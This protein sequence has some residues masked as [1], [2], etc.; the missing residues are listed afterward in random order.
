[1]FLLKL[2]SAY[3][4]CTA[5]LPSDSSVIWI[6]SHGSH[7]AL[8]AIAVIRTRAENHG[9]SIKTALNQKQ[10]NTGRS[11]GVLHRRRAGQ[12]RCCANRR[13]RAGFNWSIPPKPERSLLRLTINHSERQ[14]GRVWGVREFVTTKPPRLGPQPAAAAML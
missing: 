5:T 13:G 1:M 4:F 7:H 12:P 11:L 2:Q 6:E 10:R 9:D 14:R 3:H 8:A